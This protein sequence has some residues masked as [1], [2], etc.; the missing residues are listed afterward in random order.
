MS[1]Y[2]PA[3]IVVAAVCVFGLIATIRIGLNPEDETYNKQA[4]KRFKLLSLLYVIAFVP[5]LIWTVVYY[6]FF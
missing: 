2:I 3:L 1:N 4:R 6:Y 5:A